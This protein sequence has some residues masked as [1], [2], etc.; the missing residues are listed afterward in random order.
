MI[1]PDLAF[2]VDVGIAGDMPGVSDKD[3][4]SNLG[5]GPQLVLYDASMISHKGVRDFVVETAKSNDIPCQYA[6]RA[7]G[8]TDSSSIHLIAHG[9]ASMSI[10]VSTRYMHTL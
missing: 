6:T 8:G 1:E 5:E 3:A 2:G 10:T 9:V 7:G 4:D